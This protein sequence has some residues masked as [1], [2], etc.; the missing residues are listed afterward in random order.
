[1]TFQLLLMNNL[2]EKITEINNFVIVY[3]KKTTVTD[4]SNSLGK[5]GEAG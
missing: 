2:I 3:P 1:M 4:F 5:Q